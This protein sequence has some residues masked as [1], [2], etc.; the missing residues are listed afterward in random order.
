MLVWVEPDSSC[1]VHGDCHCEQQEVS[2]KTNGRC[3]LFCCSARFGLNPA[4]KIL[5]FEAAR[6]QF[7]RSDSERAFRK[8]LVVDA[9]LKLCTT[10]SSV[11]RSSSFFEMERFHILWSYFI[12]KNKKK[13]TSRSGRNNCLVFPLL[14]PVSIA[15]MWIHLWTILSIFLQSRNETSTIGHISFCERCREKCGAGQHG[16]NHQCPNGNLTKTRTTKKVAE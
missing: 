1:E 12:H 7:P 4:L 2:F 5:W 6:P 16:G 9:T 8:D 15:A 13:R 14:S 10:K 3:C 11:H